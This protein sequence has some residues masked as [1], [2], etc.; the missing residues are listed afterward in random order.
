MASSGPNGLEG[1]FYIHTSRRMN[2]DSGL[3][4][5]TGIL[6]ADSMASVRTLTIEHKNIKITVS[7][8]KKIMKQR[9]NW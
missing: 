4:C 2:H 7:A 8:R 1:V 5:N 3:M 6:Q 9:G